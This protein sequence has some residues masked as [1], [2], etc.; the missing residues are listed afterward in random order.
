MLAL[1]FGTWPANQSVLPYVVHKL[2]MTK[3]IFGAAT[4]YPE[5]RIFFHTDDKRANMD[6][7]ITGGW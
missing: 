5:P 3:S 2:S 7:H 6:R 1:C 4:R